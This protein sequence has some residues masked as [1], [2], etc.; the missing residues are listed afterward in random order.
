MGEATGFLKWARET[1]T[2]RPVPVRLR[3][4]KEVYE[5]FPLERRVRP[6][7]GAAWTAASRSATTAARSAT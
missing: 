3:D 1:P 7:P 2:R 4:W 5:D 6:R